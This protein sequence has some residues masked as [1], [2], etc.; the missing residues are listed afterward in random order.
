MRTPP[1]HTA[2]LEALD[3]VGDRWTLPVVAA[4]LEGPRRFAD[5]QSEVAGIA[6][7][8]LAQRLKRLES[9]GVLVAAPYTDRPPRF[10]YELTASGRDLAG[11]LRLL[12]DWGARHRAGAP[13]P[14]HAACGSELRAGWHCATCDRPVADDEI[15]ELHYA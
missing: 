6:S 7:N 14:R 13:A 12:I 5:L 11:A 10:V 3:V 8:V 4:L 1:P 2:L 15:G 9:Q